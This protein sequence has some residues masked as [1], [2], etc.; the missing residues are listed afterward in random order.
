MNQVSVWGRLSLITLLSLTLGGCFYSN[1]PPSATATGK[2]MYEEYCAGCHKASGIGKFV[3]GIPATF[4]NNLSRTEII[5]LIRE[6]DPRYPRMP[7][8]P[9]IKFTQADKIARYLDELE[10]KK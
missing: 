8:F 9:Q 10:H 2:Q 4:S 6:G 5:K 3:M 7:V 1:D